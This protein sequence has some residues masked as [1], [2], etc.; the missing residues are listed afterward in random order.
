MRHAPLVENII[1]KKSSSYEIK[2]RGSYAVVNVIS[3]LED[4]SS[5][6]IETKSTNCGRDSQLPSKLIGHW[7]ANR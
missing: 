1:K 2:T 3:S 7:D 6:Y 4:K 5:I